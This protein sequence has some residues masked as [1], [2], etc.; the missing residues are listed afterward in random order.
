[1][2]GPRCRGKGDLQFFLNDKSS[3]MFEEQK[4][5]PAGGN[6]IIRDK[7]T[8]D[9]TALVCGDTVYLYTGHDEPP[10]GVDD[11]VMNDWLCFSSRDMVTWQDHGVLLKATDFAWASGDA[12]ASKVIEKEGK[13]YWYVAVSHAL[14]KG[15]AIGVAVAD[16]PYGPF[17]DARGSALISSDMIPETDDNKANLDPTV[18]IDNSGQA[19]IFWGHK[20]CYCARLKSNMTE[21]DGPVNIIELPEFSEGA[22]IHQRG[23]WFYLAYGYGFPERVGYAMSRSVE[24]P[25]QFAGMINEVPENCET[26]RPA[27]IDFRKRSWFLYHNGALKGGGSHRRSVCVDRIYYNEDGTIRPVLMTKEGVIL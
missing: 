9:P 17:I 21:L 26:N 11:Y 14:I 5:H 1:M 8:A 3:L 7:F 22:H 15:T 27:I 10:E 20:T 25:W 24:G 4:R 18:I 2:K 13:F 12:F 6:P 19:Y 16:T 23:E